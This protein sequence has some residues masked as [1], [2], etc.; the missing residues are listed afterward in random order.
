MIVR[1]VTKGDIDAVVALQPLA[2]PPPFDPDLLW[3]REHIERHVAIFPEGQF[4]A[5]IDGRVV[6][7]CSNTRISEERWTAHQGWDATVGGPLLTTY[8]PSGTTL[9][10]LDISVHPDFRRLGIGRALYRAR[11]ALVVESG[12]ARYGTACRMPDFA[13]A[14]E[15][16]TPTD[17]GVAVARGEVADRTLTPLLRMGLSY[18]GIIDGYMDDPE[19]GNAAAVLEV[20]AS[21]CAE[22]LRGS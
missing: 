8:D 6:G 4:L 13:S 10:G 9:Y 12:L 19:S 5:E 17:Y 18:G 20:S 16:I 3:Q 15:L 1:N 21:R 7:S 22:M 14:G 11:F 2:F